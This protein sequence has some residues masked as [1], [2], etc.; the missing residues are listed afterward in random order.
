[1]DPRGEFGRRYSEIVLRAWEDPAFKRRLMA[2]P[3][4]VLREY[5]I[6]VPDRLEIRVVE[7]TDDVF[8][9]NLPAKPSTELTA[10]ELDALTGAGFAYGVPSSWLL[11]ARG[12]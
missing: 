1:M 8:Y 4:A 12:D 3:K 10:E 7:N 2:D 9:L 5:G 6:E 11:N